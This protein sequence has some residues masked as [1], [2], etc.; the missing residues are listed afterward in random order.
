MPFK[1]REVHL[2]YHKDYIKK[3]R[4]K[5]RARK[6]K[7]THGISIEDYNGILLKQHG[8]CAICLKPETTITR[9][10]LQPLAVDHNHTINEVRGLLCIKCNTAIGLLDD[11]PE[12][13]QA[14]IQYLEKYK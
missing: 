4:D 5:I 10:H 3:N 14:L 7:Q 6:I 1:N 11:S 13:A 8:I 2:K 12:R 9:G